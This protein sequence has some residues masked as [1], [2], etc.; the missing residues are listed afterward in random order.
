MG[1]FNDLIFSKNSIVFGVA[2]AV[3]GLVVGQVLSTTMKPEMLPYLIAIGMAIAIFLIVILYSSYLARKRDQLST[4]FFAPRTY[5][6]ALVSTQPLQN[7]LTEVA[8]E[9]FGSAVPD[10]AVTNAIWKANA[11]KSIV[12]RNVRTGKVEGY[13]ACWPMTDQAGGDLLTGKISAEGIAAADIVDATQNGKARYLLI[14]GLGV[15]DAD[16]IRRG[17]IKSRTIIFQFFELLLAEFIVDDKFDREIIFLT[18]SVRGKI[19][20]N[21]PA[22]RNL[23]KRLDGAGINLNATYVKEVTHYGEKDSLWVVRVNR[24]RLMSIYDDVMKE[25]LGV[26]KL[27]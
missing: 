17:P 3:L 4:Y 1:K 16:S 11:K 22:S 19:G 9:I 20:G 8:S 7:E 24:T 27:V 26:S 2:A 23:M 25:S 18:H 6:C 12:L 5:R 21:L 15:T 13:A 10:E 14:P